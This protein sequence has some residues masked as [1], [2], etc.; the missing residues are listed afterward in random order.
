M[1]RQT[2]LSLAC[3]L[4]LNTTQASD[5][6][7]DSTFATSQY[8]GGW[9]RLYTTGASL[10]ERGVGLARTA[11][12][13]YVACLSVPGGAAGAQIGLMRFD[14]SG[15]VVATFGVGGKVV[16]DANL[17]SV[18]DMTIDPQGRIVVIGSTPGAG[19]LGDF[20]VVRFNA[21]GSDDTSFAGDG[22]TSFGFDN[23]SFSFDDAP[24]SVLAQADSKIVVAGTTIA[25]ASGY[26]S[27]VSLVRFN[28]D[29]SLD[30]TFGNLGGAVGS[31][32][33]T[34]T[35]FVSGQGASAAKLLRVVGGYFVVVGTSAIS[36]TNRDFAARIL[37]PDGSPWAGDASALTIA[38]DI[39]GWGGTK[40]DDAFDAA[41]VDATTI[42]IV[43]TASNAAAA[44]RIVVNPP[45]GYGQ[46]TSLSRDPS[47]LGNGIAIDNNTFV[48]NEPGDYAAYGVAIAP[49]RRIVMVGSVNGGIV[50]NGLV[51]RLTS[52]G[53]EDLTVTGSSYFRDYA[54][55]LYNTP[56][57]Y[58]TF[59]RVVF[60]AARPVVLGTSAYSE[61]SA[62]DLD[63]VMVRLDSDTIF[64]NGYE[65]VP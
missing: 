32:R 63:G 18:T 19:G 57:A 26:T 58:T 12:G 64:A 27:K 16:K 15:N 54:A 4:V 28:A 13:G 56:S 31:R 6:D 45:N 30:G 47:F 41:A 62:T 21:D 50:S 60:D 49:D 24:K 61:T 37:L 20:G 9:A 34:F 38:F 46:Y 48:T 35:E 33:G 8:R 29:G 14:A 11:D 3:C 10:D 5:F 55:P 42:V 23:S 44:T 53:R 39:P 51:M 7:V 22:G 52:D 59:R 2:L 43:G 36:S 17:S 40:F 65:A 1:I 25:N